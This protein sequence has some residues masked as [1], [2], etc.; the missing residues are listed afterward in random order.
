[1]QSTEITIRDI[2][3]L[4]TLKKDYKFK[5]TGTVRIEGRCEKVIKEVRFTDQGN[6]R[7][8]LDRMIKIYRPN[9]TSIK[10]FVLFD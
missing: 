2:I 10:L 8:L 9:N 7:F 6:L 1:M 5:F 4:E 3:G